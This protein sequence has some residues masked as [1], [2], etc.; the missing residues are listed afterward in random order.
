MSDSFW[1]YGL[2][3][4]RLLYPGDSLVKNTGVGCHALLQGSS[5]PRDRTCV[6]YVSCLAGR[7]FTTNATWEAQLPQI[8]FSWS[9]MTVNYVFLFNTQFLF[10]FKNGIQMIN[11]QLH[12]FFWKKENLMI[13]SWNFKAKWDLRII[14]IVFFCT[15]LSSFILHSTV[16]SFFSASICCGKICE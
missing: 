13:G 4:T 15:F 2:W 9:L 7:F 12:S 8:G 10:I 1:P 16:L 5:W 6:S 11:N 14:I 3:P